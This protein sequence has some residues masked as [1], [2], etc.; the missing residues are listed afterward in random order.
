M[1][2]SWH[3]SSCQLRGSRMSII[4]RAADL[5]SQNDRHETRSAPSEKAETRR[6]DWIE[7]ASADLAEGA[8][9]SIDG[10]A[11]VDARMRNV[12]G[13][14]SNTASPR[15]FAIDRDRL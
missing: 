5:L 4:E 15:Q 9:V 7:R 14:P 13:R 12:P 8:H 6:A 1:V 10:V 11:R 2:P 3:R